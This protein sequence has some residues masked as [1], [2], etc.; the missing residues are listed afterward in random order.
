METILAVIG[1]AL[2][3]QL[4]T[5][6]THLLTLHR[7]KLKAKIDQEASTK[8]WEREEAAR[9][10]Q[11]NHE[12]KVQDQ[13]RYRES[14]KE[15][16]SASEVLLRSAQR[17]IHSETSWPSQQDIQDAL[18]QVRAL[19][20]SDSRVSISAHLLAEA[21]SEKVKRGKPMSN[22]FFSNVDNN[23]LSEL[24]EVRIGNFQNALEKIP[25]DFKDLRDPG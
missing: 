13:E 10:N 24:I 12:I 19:T 1:G 9:E 23:D 2:I 5:L 15:I 11:R 22:D 20:G 8:Q 21:L 4:G 25:S 16:R 17:A 14:Q 7:D 6:V 3:G 18:A